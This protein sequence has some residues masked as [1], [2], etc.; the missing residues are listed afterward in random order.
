[1]AANSSRLHLNPNFYLEPPSDRRVSETITS[2]AA[3]SSAI[4]LSAKMYPESVV[5]DLRSIGPS[6]KTEQGIPVKEQ[7]AIRCSAIRL[8][9]NFYP[10]SDKKK[11]NN[12]IKTESVTGPQSSSSSERFC[13]NF[14]AE[15][16]SDLGTVESVGE[17]HLTAKPDSSSLHLGPTF[18]SDTLP[19]KS[20]P[21][22]HRQ[23]H[24]KL[25]PFT[26]DENYDT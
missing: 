3:T 21:P 12:E 8:N 11:S 14:Y 6:I 18:Y 22:A 13:P 26:M 25:P 9:P 15:T 16:M 23:K 20:P 4:P 24:T 1:M 7:T 2:R 10:D 19:V 17:P 5:P